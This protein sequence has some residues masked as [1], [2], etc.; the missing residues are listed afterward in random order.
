[1][2]HFQPF[3]PATLNGMYTTNTTGAQQTFDAAL[4]DSVG[5]NEAHSNVMLTFGINY[6]MATA[7]LYPPRPSEEA[8]NG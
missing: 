8:A 2:R 3:F 4:L 5:G 1:M 6:M 7:G